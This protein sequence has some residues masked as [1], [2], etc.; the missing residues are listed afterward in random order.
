MVHEEVIHLH[1]SFHLR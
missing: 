1:P